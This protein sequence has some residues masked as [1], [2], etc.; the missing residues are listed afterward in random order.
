MNGFVQTLKKHRLATITFAVICLGVLSGILAWS[1]L[2]RRQQAVEPTVVSKTSAVSILGVEKTTVGTSS[3]L[4]VKLQNTS[5]KDIKAYTIGTETS[6]MTRNYLLREESF[7]SGTTVIHLIP[8]SGEDSQSLQ[9]FGDSTTRIFITAVIFTDGTGD[10]E[11]R[12]VRMLLDERAGT[13]DQANRIL[14]YLRALSSPGSDRGRALS[15]FEAKVRSLPDKRNESPSSAD[16]DIGLANAK[17]ELLKGTEDM[18]E[19]IQSNRPDEAA[20]KQEKITRIFQRLAE[21]P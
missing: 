15:D 2:A 21:S 20:I 11:A 16:Y 12:F 7:A 3:I 17:R 14:A 10:G 4:A 1:G 19:K 5:D 8:L 9:T 18:K 13:R 6:W